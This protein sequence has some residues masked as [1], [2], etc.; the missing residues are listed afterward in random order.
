[1]FFNI[2]FKK[3]LNNLLK[4]RSFSSKSLD[5][6]SE[7]KSPDSRSNKRRFKTIKDGKNIEK[8]INEYRFD[9]ITSL[10]HDYLDEHREIRE[11]YRKIAWELPTLTKFSMKYKVPGKEDILKFRYTTYL[12]EKHPAESKVTMEVLLDSLN[13]SM[14]ERHKLIVL[15]GPRYNPLTGVLKL[16]CELF[17]ER[18]KNKKH[19]NEQLKRLIKEAKDLKDT[20]EDIPQDFRHV[21][22][23]KNITF[24]KEWIK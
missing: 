17:A 24:P 13:L 20:F 14:T 6:S 19:L 3:P 8:H 11:Y 21:K 5:S 23:K 9:D 7:L 2:F 22:S 15:S 1:M 18:D 4:I 10:A 16:S 12:G